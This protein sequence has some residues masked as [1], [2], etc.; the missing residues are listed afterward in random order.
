M[1][2][3][4]LDSLGESVFE[5]CSSLVSIALPESLKQIPSSTFYGC[6]DL[7][8]L[9][10]SSL[11]NYI[12][13]DAFH[14]CASLTSITIPRGVS[15]IY[16]STF[17]GCLSMESIQ[18][19]SANPW[20]ASDNGVLFTRDRSEL[21]AYP[22]AR[23]GSY[24]IP[25]TVG[26][27]TAYSFMDCVGLSGITFGNSTFG[28]QKYAFA[29]CT[30]LETI[31][32]GDSVRSLSDYSFA[33][34]T[35]LKT[36]A[37]GSETRNFTARVFMD[38]PSLTRIDVADDNAE[39]KS[40]DG[41]LFDKS[42]S[43]LLCYPPAHTGSSYTV[44]N[45]VQYLADNA[46][47]GSEG[48]VSIEFPSSVIFIGVS[49]FSDCTALASAPLPSALGVVRESA[50]ENCAK[51][52]NVVVPSGVIEIYD[53]TFRN[54]TSLAS[55]TFPSG[56]V[57]IGIEAFFG[58]SS[59]TSLTLPPALARYGID[60][61]QS[62]GKLAQFVVSAANTS[63]ASLDGVLFNKT[64]TR[65]LQYPPARLGSYKVP[66]SVT[67]ISGQAFLGSTG[68]TS[69]SIGS[70]VE[71]IGANALSM[72]SNLTRIDVDASNSA[73]SSL[74]GILLNK[75]KTELV[76]YPGGRT[77]TYSIPTG[78]T[79]IADYA[80]AGCTELT[81]INLPSG[82]SRLG[83]FSFYDCE[84][85]S[86]ITLPASVVQIGAGSFSACIS[87]KRISVDSANPIY[88]SRDG[89]LFDKSGATLLQYPC[90]TAGGYVV[91]E[92][93]A[94]IG[95]NSFSW[96]LELTSVEMPESLT[97]IDNFAFFGCIDLATIFYKGNA[98]MIGLGVFDVC[99]FEFESRYKADRLGFS[100]PEWEGYPSSV[101][102]SDLQMISF[103]SQGGT[104]VE[105]RTAEKGTTVCEPIPPMKPGYV[106]TGWFTAPTGGTKVVF[107]CLVAGEDTFYAQWA[108]PTQISTWAF[109]IDPD[110]GII[111]GIDTSTTI[112]TL[113]DGLNE[114]ECIRI[115]KGANSVTGSA[116]LGSGMQV[117]LMDGDVVV[118]TLVVVVTGDV[119]GD[120]RIT[121]TD[122]VQMKAHLLEVSPLTGPYGTACDVNGDGRITLTDFIKMK[123]HL[124]EIDPIIPQTH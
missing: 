9:T 46:F 108:K 14:D 6:E 22:T 16:S 77:G 124:L 109:H 40:I 41:V 99:S 88:S 17:N 81:G 18:V 76:Q 54:C 23:V 96:S 74:N 47:M 28:I 55:V 78:V 73:Y 89:V 15:F 79:V 98:P 52:A 97:V 34:C 91:P 104:S 48:L 122:Y 110:S 50:F 119:N 111:S 36:V 33:G 21:I 37:A 113:L 100:T 85:L 66:S 72:C 83:F 35:S 32:F 105:A 5:G 86:A 92:G 49:C 7:V 39:I 82:L 115:L 121:L 64:A 45:G 80:F 70:A 120:G 114:K 123:A 8:N 12:G 11:L 20:L 94:R 71:S 112:D 93:V 68:I 51:L 1:W 25:D 61:F 118:Q 75:S 42:A 103:D 69:L 116:L 53:F 101:Y 67:R 90:G 3:S 19:D 2:A 57:T 30:G 29:G 102:L 24:V 13:P 56:L 38:C 107:P 58:C 87:M 65:L 106:F 27:I 4:T 10:F 63:F 44:P 59:L 60:A 95:S 26:I 62:C 43:V 84:S 31:D 117:Q